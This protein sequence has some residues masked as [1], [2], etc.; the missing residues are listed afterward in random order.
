MTTINSN[1]GYT[2]ASAQAVEQT[3]GKALA[4]SEP[5][6]KADSVALKPF[7]SK[8]VSVLTQGIKLGLSLVIQGSLKIAKFTAAAS[9]KVG[10]AFVAAVKAASENKKTAEAQGV[11]PK[12]LTKRSPTKVNELKEAQKNLALAVRD[13]RAT[14]DTQRALQKDRR[15]IAALERRAKALKQDDVSPAKKPNQD[16]TNFEKSG[17]TLSANATLNSK[18]KQD[19]AELEKRLNALKKA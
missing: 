5:N 2:S 18:D 12:A 4:Q 6:A 13:G 3:T 14:L 1:R 17:S 9:L 15:D 8:T 16:Y 10:K 7:L 11:Q 19:I